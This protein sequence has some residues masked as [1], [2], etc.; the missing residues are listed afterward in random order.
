M[1]HLSRRC[2]VLSS[3]STVTKVASE[4]TVEVDGVP[5]FRQDKNISIMNFNNRIYILIGPSGVGVRVGVGVGVTLKSI[6]SAAT[7][8]QLQC[9]RSQ[10]AEGAENGIRAGDDQETADLEQVG[11]GCHVKVRR[12]T[13]RLCH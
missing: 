7:S 13:C 9:G 4:Q 5:R 10:T 8:A 11:R 2:D 1:C 3:V 6:D 12:C